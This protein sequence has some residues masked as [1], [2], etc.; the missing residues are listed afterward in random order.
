MTMIQIKYTIRTKGKSTGLVRTASYPTGLCSIAM[1]TR[2]QNQS[3]DE[4]TTLPVVC[5]LVLEPLPVSLHA[6]DFFAVVV[7]HGVGDRVGR[8]IHAITAD[9]VE[10]L[11]FF[12]NAEKMRC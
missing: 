1:H 10:E 8:G 6:A 5:P 7:R 3:L 11:L 12:L 4:V 2:K 9:A